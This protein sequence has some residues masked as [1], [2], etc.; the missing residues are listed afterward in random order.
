MQSS[1]FLN[2]LSVS[3]TFATNNT[4]MSNHSKLRG[5]IPFLCFVFCTFAGIAIGYMSGTITAGTLVGLGAGLI[6]MVLLRFIL[7]RKKDI[8]ENP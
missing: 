1:F 6:L 5:R 7:Y 2:K 3:F 4:T 8:E